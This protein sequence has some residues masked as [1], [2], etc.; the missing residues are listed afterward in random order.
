[1]WGLKPFETQAGTNIL[2]NTN[3]SMLYVLNTFSCQVVSKMVYIKEYHL[4]Y[5]S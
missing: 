1:M 4:L 5:S 3:F 2:T